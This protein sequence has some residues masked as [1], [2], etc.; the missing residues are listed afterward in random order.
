MYRRSTGTRERENSRQKESKNGMKHL[1]R[2]GRVIDPARRMDARLNV[3]LENGKILCLTRETPPAD[4]T[5]DAE[6]L[7]VCPGFIDLHAHE[8]P[9]VEGVRDRDPEKANLACLLRMGV[10]TC[11]AGNCGDNF[12]DP[13]AF[14]DEIDC[15]G[16][17]VNVAMLAGYTWFREKYSKADCYTAASADEIETISGALT[18]ALNAGCAGV[19][20]GLEYVPGMSRD[21]L[22][23]AARCCRAGGK[24]IAAHIRAC[25]EGAPAAAAEVLRA[26]KEA[27]VPVQISHIGSMAAYGQME[28]LLTL[29][30]LFRAEGV[31]ACCDCYPYAAFSTRIGSAPYDDLDAMHCSYEDIELCEGI[32]RGERCTKEIFEAERKAHPDYL[33]V[34]HVMNEDEIRLAYRHPN[35]TV[36]SDCFLFGGNGHPRAAG[37]FPR[38]LGRLAPESGL[39]LNE[40][41]FRITALPALRLGLAE[42]GTLRPGADADLVLFDPEEICD[43]ATFD[44]PTLPPKGI[45]AVFLA[46]EPAVLDGKIVNGRLGRPIRR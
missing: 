43:C 10:T 2:N 27:S 26:G 42:K 16:C 33:T 12:G 23:A 25:A 6:G 29:V 31:D 24:L 3:L 35:V 28:E 5:T 44:E 30:D 20:F 18:A 46:G 9:L 7:V 32:H 39:S 34:G 8:D 21:E 40:A 19:S 15:F 45:K 37:A 17:F 22:L 41:L 38:F 11:L 1:I 14:L 13:A 36:G 4:L